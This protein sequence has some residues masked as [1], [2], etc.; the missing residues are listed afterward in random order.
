MN[1]HQQ[2]LDL[3][4]V[5]LLFVGF[6]VIGI[7]FPQS[8]GIR[9]PKGLKPSSLFFRIYAVIATL[10][11]LGLVLPSAWSLLTKR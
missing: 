6:G 5:G 11:G 2:D 4:G 1:P 10:F 8:Y 7:I 3:L 9:W